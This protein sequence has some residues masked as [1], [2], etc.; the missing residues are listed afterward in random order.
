M[1]DK[2]IQVIEGTPPPMPL[3]PLALIQQAIHK[4]VDADYMGKLMDLQ[5]RWEKGIAVKE[6]NTAMQAAQAE[7]GVIICDSFNPQTKSKY[8]SVESINRT[9]K[10]IYTRHGFALSFDEGEAIEGRCRTTCEV[11]HIG[12]HSKHYHLDLALDGKGIKG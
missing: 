3:H 7:M 9:I 1:S 6:F 4:G 11:M 10:P 5:E 8:P 2:P 12:G